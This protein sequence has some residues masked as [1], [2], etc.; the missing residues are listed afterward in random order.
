MLVVPFIGVALMVIYPVVVSLTI[1]LKIMVVVLFVG[2]VLTVVYIV[3]LSEPIRLEIMVVE[4]AGLVPMVFYL[5][6]HLLA[7]LLIWVVVSPGI[8]L[9]VV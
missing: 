3:L 2:M 8:T 5:V 4:S 6:V 9:M 1:L 7:T